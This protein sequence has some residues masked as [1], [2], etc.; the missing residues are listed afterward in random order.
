[1]GR[2]RM[3][4]DLSPLIGRVGATEEFEIPAADIAEEGFAAHVGAVRIRATNCGASIR[5]EGSFSS[6]VPL[7]CSRCL[8]TFDEHVAERIDESI[9]IRFSAPDSDQFEAA[10]EYDLSILSGSRVDVVELIRQQILTA[11]PMLPVCSA[12]CPGLCPAC[13][14]RRDACSCP[15]GANGEPKTELGRLLANAFKTEDERGNRD[16]T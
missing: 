9:P 16:G 6:R 8:A 11:L 5:I 13:G 1:M 2:K 14:E 12:G 15:G 3:L 7:E 4:L 10:D